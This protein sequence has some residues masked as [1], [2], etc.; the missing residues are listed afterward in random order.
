MDEYLSTVE[1]HEVMNLAGATHSE[2]FDNSVVQ[3]SWPTQFLWACMGG[4]VGLA[5]DL[6]DQGVNIN[7]VDS[8]NFSGFHY[9]CDYRQ[10]V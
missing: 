1:L 3:A 2:L 8:Q 10:W 7:A 5:N 6:A 9:A 4:R